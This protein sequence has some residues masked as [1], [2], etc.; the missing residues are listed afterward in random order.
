MRELI[1][2][3]DAIPTGP[4]LMERTAWLESMV[5]WLRAPGPVPSRRGRLAPVESAGSA[6]LR[7]LV[8]VLTESPA[9]C[10]ELRTLVRSVLAETS[11]LMLLTDCGL[12]AGRG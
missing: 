4:S 8:E 6:R 5:T 2:L 1:S 3:L 11:A 10:E 12:S 9:W 7:L